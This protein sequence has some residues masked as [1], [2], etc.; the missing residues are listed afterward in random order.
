MILNTLII[1]PILGLIYI[2]LINSYDESTNKTTVKRMS[3]FASLFNL[4]ISCIL[5][6]L[7]DNSSKYI[8]FS[9]QQEQVSYYDFFLGVDGLSIYFI[10]LTSIITPVS[11]ISN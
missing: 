11:I 4:F 9:Q 3:L 5:W 7:F 10:L 2:I 6:V 8:Q 1:T